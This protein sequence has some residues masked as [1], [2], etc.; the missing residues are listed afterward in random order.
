MVLT[1]AEARANAARETSKGHLG[2]FGDWEYYAMPNRQ[3]YRALRN[4]PMDVWGYRQGPRW[5]CFQR[6]WPRE[7]GR[8]KTQYGYDGAVTSCS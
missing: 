4:H 2:F 3:V 5:V 1:T 6:D 8:L 7:H